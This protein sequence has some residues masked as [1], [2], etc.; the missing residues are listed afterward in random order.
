MLRSTGKE[1]AEMA[2][3]VAVRSNSVIIQDCEFEVQKKYYEQ[4]EE[5]IFFNGILLNPP[6][7][8]PGPF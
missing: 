1:E 3:Q 8:I 5:C 4:E 6:L 2:Q 7:P